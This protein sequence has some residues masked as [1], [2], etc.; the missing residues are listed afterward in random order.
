M[1]MRI[2]HAQPIVQGEG[3]EA[4]RVFARPLLTEEEA[5]LEARMLS[6]GRDDI[7]GVFGEM[8]G[9]AFGLYTHRIRI[10]TGPDHL[11]R[12]YFVRLAP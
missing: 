1:C 2:T 12:E 7:M 3:E 5:A 9:I 11:C 10:D 4:G 6:W 8:D